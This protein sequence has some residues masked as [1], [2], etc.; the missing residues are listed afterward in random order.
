MITVLET[1]IYAAC[2]KEGCGMI[3]LK[4]SFLLLYCKDKCESLSIS[5]VKISNDSWYCC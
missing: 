5:K 4:E 2:D 1:K 3:Y